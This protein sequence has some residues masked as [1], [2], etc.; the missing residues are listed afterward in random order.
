MTASL[1]TP[2]RDAF[3]VEAVRRDFPI[4]RL[5]VEGHPLVYLDNAATTQK[6]EAVIEAVRGYYLTQNANI[7]RGV[8]H[9]SQ[10][11]TEAYEESRRKVQRL[12][13]ARQAA[14]V[15]FVR[16]ATEGVNLVAQSF[17]RMRVRPGDE[18]LI[19]AMEHHSN[20]VPWQML[21][22]QT[23]ARLRVAPMNR[24]GELV[25]EE[26]R[27]KLTPRTRLAAVVYVSNA[28]GTVNPAA[29]L[30][31]AAHAA[32]VPV[33]LDAAQAVPHLPIDVQE[34][35][36]D[37]LVFSGH[38]MYGPTG[39]GVVYGKRDLL[40]AMPPYQGGGEMIT[41]VTFEETVYNEVPHKF[42]AGTPNVAGAVGLGVAV[43]YLESL[44]L[45][46]IQRYEE[47]LLAYA[48]ESL[49]H[50]SEVTIIGTASRKAGAVSFV[51]NGVHPHDL[52]TVLDRQGIAIRAGHHCAQPVMDFFGIPATARAS[53][54]FYNTR[55]EI[56]CLVRGLRQAMEVFA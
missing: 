41:S 13:N 26:F 17:G 1:E 12:I 43:D 53:L 22:E 44:G 51:V 48:E 32:G 28:L 36:V 14:E 33:L 16:G 34:L 52:G 11:A 56:D 23:G 37:F 20:I 29:E 15:V 49:S 45:E 47:E 8:H 38:K 40:D 50:F 21:C 2:R 54:A 7:H 27:A 24:R 42:E 30:I 35:D 18:V 4:L 19:T 46:R 3:D 10:V 9:L 5:E 39:I 31:E 6:P 55:N 25:L